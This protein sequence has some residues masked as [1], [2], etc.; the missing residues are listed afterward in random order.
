MPP[1][2]SMLESR[3]GE[4][5][6]ET[7]KNPSG[8]N[9]TERFS[10]VR[11]EV[12]AM[13]EQRLREIKIK[14]IAV[15]KE[16]QKYIEENLIYHFNLD[17]PVYFEGRPLRANPIQGEL[18]TGWRDPENE[19]FTFTGGNRIGKT[20]IGTIIIIAV[21]FGKW[22]WSN[23]RIHFN[24]NK[25]R[26]IRY[27]GQDWEKHIKAVTIPALEKWWPKTRK[28]KKKKNNQGID[29][30]WTDEATGSTLEIMSNEQKSTMHEGWDGDLVIY[31]EPP[32]RDIRVANARGC[33][34][35]LGRELFTMTLL[36]E[37][38][39]D[40]EVIKARN[41]DGTPDRSV[42]NVH[43][44]IDV[45]VGYG[46]TQ[47][48]VDQFAKK[49]NEDE[50]DARLKGIPSYM[51]GLIYN[52]FSRST[53][54]IDRFEIPMDWMVDVA[55]DVHPVKPQAILFRATAPNNE[56]F[57]FDEIFH[58][59]DGKWIAEQIV[60]KKLDGHL[61]INKI[62]I[63]PLAKGDSN[64]DHTTFD[65]IDIV[66]S[67]HGMVLDTATKDKDSGIRGV[68]GR[69]KTPNGGTGL[70][71]F[72]DLYR[73]ILEI[74][75]FMVDPKT[76]KPQKTMDDMMENLYRLELIGTEW[77]PPDEEYDDVDD[78]SQPQSCTGY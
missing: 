42:F 61:R 54:L 31:D 5:M 53:H 78:Y 59:G 25:P 52:E 72:R 48:G 70:Y 21:M 37:A 32:K 62:I 9:K 46:I 63:D 41:K 77:E 49:L 58:N 75:G 14:K 51:S 44:A 60:K 1:D 8:V 26:K 34:D 29:A 39:V 43:G 38:W 10:G 73:T 74:E 30:L 18:L 55:I 68:K 23:E 45:N 16:K 67:R 65:T 17:P 19:V 3:T 7:A 6:P 35:R 15:L 50:K 40:Q 24:H 64:N 69:L 20:T 4:I 66:L 27:V 57:V 11:D 71:F 12:K 47:E 22:P 56:Q 36:S 33:V 13:K 2:I 28:V 76:G